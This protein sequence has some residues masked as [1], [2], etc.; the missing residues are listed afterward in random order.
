MTGFHNGEECIAENLELGYILIEDETII[1]K[2]RMYRLCIDC[3]AP[4]VWAAI[5]ECQCDFCN[6]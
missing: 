3:D 2:H 5:Y 6:Y 4:K 1:D